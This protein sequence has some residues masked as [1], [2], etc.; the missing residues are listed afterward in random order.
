M[1]TP[2]LLFAI[3]FVVM[4]LLCGMASGLALWRVKNVEPGMVFR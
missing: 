4:I 3:T 2:G 1:Q